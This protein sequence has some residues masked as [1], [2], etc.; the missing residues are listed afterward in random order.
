[1]STCLK[2]KEK[3]LETKKVSE[4]SSKIRL[5]TKYSVLHRS[6]EVIPYLEL[7]VQIILLV[8]L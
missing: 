6:R 1:M 2:T 3:D 4:V 5:E 8:T 7:G